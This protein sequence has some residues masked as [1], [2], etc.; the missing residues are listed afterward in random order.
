MPK[1]KR[2][3]SLIISILF[4][5]LLAASLFIIIIRL[6]PN[7]GLSVPFRSFIV[8]SGSMEPSIMTGDLLLVMPQPSYQLNDVVTFHDEQDRIVTHRIR[9]IQPNNNSILFVTKGDANRA[10]DAQII[11][12]SAIIGKVVLTLPKLGFV[13]DFSRSTLGVIVFIV[14]PGTI[15]VSDEFRVLFKKE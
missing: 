14:I 1:V 13:A 6:F 10:V 9:E 3:I 12:P 15:I 2:K 8:Q 4:W 5:S 11:P 7:L